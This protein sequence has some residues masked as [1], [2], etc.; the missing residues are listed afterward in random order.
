MTGEV[1]VNV[2]IELAIT[3]FTTVVAVAADAAT[4][5]IIIAAAPRPKI[6]FRDIRIFIFP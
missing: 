6:A 4:G 1:V 2:E 5:A 3:A